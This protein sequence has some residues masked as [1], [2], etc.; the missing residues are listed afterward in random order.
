MFWYQT[1]HLLHYSYSGLQNCMFERREHYS[2]FAHSPFNFAKYN[3]T[4]HMV[5]Q[6]SWVSQ[7]A[8][9]NKISI[10]PQTPI[11]EKDAK[12]T[13]VVYYGPISA[14]IKKVKLLSLST[15]C[16]S[17]S[18]G[19]IITF[20]TSP[21]LNVI[22][23][24]AVASSVILMSATTTGALHWFVSPYIHK[25][26]WKPGS[27]NCEV[28]MMSWM[29]SLIPRTIKFGDIK[30]AETNRPYVSFEAGNTYYF[31]DAEHCHNKALLQKL[32]PEKKKNIS[33]SAFKN[34]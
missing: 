9:S 7:V 2:V 21:D 4:K 1:F 10:G 32:T 19:P 16:L 24:G 30:A 25:L 14:T 15:C 6:K 22:I 31:I 12:D 28:E 20:M 26:K 34:L 3:F 23:K 11:R 33:Q 8:S 27:D 13:D 17:I 18:L 5:C 29:A